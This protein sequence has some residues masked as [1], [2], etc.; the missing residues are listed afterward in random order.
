MGRTAGG[1][2]IFRRPGELKWRV[3][4]SHGGRQYKLSTGKEDDAEARVVAAR[5]YAETISGTR[6]EPVRRQR[7]HRVGARPLGEVAADWLNAIEG[8]ID[9]DT[10]GLWALYAGTHWESFFKTIEGITTS[11]AKAY[12][13]ERLKKVKGSTVRKELGALRNLCNW[14]FGDNSPSIPGISK[15]MQGTAHPQGKRVRTELSPDECWSVIFHLDKCSTS[16]RRPPFPV[17]AYFVVLYETGLRPATLAALSVP[18]HYTKG[19][20]ELRIPPEL[21]KT[22]AGRPYPLSD[23]ARAALD[24][25]C[26]DEGVIFGEHDYRDALARAAERSGLAPHKRATLHPY[27]FRAAFATHFAEGGDLLALQYLMGH[28][29]LSTTSI[30][31]KPS[32]RAAIAALESAGR[33]TSGK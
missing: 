28:A 14:H 16:K 3:S 12:T 22:R 33:I 9:V 30:Y 32:L 7:A 19:D 29:S 31:A 1:W 17:R 18:E 20:R 5:L 27:D 24:G 13:L 25:V 8:T 15:R 23:R 10:A 4:F 21:D 2:R 26:P 11:S 6:A